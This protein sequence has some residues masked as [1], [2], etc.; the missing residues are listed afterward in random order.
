MLYKVDTIMTDGSTLKNEV[1]FIAMNIFIKKKTL[2]SLE[3][4]INQD[5]K[6]MNFFNVAVTSIID[7][8]IY[9]NQK[10]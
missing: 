5:Y 6:T 4:F 9:K 8:F 1:Y 2:F 7:V 10:D 3:T